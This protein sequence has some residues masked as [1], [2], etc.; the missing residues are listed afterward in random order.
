LVLP[1]NAQT[2]AA[3][4]AVVSIA[5]FGVEV[6]VLKEIWKKLDYCFLS[7]P[8]EKKRRVK[9]GVFLQVIF[10][11]VALGAYTIAGM[12]DPENAIAIFFWV[13]FISAVIMTLALPIVR[14]T[15]WLKGK[16]ESTI[17]E[18]VDVSSVFFVA[19]F[20]FLII[21][22][23]SNL[24]A[25]IGVGAAMLD[26]KVGI[27]DIESYV[28]GKWLM[29]DAIMFFVLGILIVGVAYLYENRKRV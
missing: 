14:V 18:E 28:W 25:L 21:G 17:I 27:W 20:V 12:Y 15:S 23:L 11:S 10:P 7:L 9:W 24:A 29:V 2:I 3:L 16:K 19:G 13:V 26:I 8:K 1:E 4:V 22:V 5:L 6:L